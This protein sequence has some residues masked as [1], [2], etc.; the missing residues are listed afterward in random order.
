VSLINGR[1]AGRLLVGPQCR[2]EGARREA[3]GESQRPR[4]LDHQQSE[5]ATTAMAQPQRLERLLDSLCLS[6]PIEKALF[7]LVL[8]LCLIVPVVVL[9]WDGLRSHEM[10]EDLTKWSDEALLKAQRGE[11]LSVLDYPPDWP[12]R[13]AAE[14]DIIR[15]PFALLLLGYGLLWIGRGFRKSA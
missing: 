9:E 8:S 10:T 5:V 13:F 12:R 14:G 15:P 1:L 4:R 2:S 11:S 7:W 3:C 6:P